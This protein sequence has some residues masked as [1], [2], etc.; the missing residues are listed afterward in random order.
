MS[1]NVKLTLMNIREQVKAEVIKGVEGIEGLEG[2]EGIEITRTADPKFGDF[3]TNLALKVAKSPSFAKASEGKQRAKETKGFKGEQSPMEFAKVLTDSL[4]KSKLVKKLE[5]KEPG[6]VNFWVKD[7]IW[8]KEVGNVLKE[9]VKYGSNNYGEGKKARVEF[10]S[11][12]P[13]GPIHFGNARGG[14]IGDCLASVLSKSGYKVKREYYHNDVGVQV[15]KL[16]ESIKNVHDGKRLE[17]QEYKGQYVAE[18]ADKIGKVA[19]AKEAGK[20]AVE[21]LLKRAIEDSKSMGII[22]DEVYSE[23]E[24]IS[25]GKTK[26]ALAKLEKMGKLV[27]KDGAV[28]FAAEG[29]FLKDRECVVVKGDGSYTYFANDISYH[30]LKFRE[31]PALVIDVFGSNHHGHVPRLQAAVKE[32]GWDVSR[33]HV[34]L[35][36]WVRF[37]SGGKLASMSKRA[38]TLVTVREVLDEVGCDSLRFFILMHDPASHID[39]DLSL[40][41]DKSSKNPVYYVQY[42]HA[43]ICSILSKA[44]PVTTFPPASAPFASLRVNSKPDGEKFTPK[45]S[46][47]RAVGSLSSRATRKLEVNYQLLTTN[48]ELALIKKITELP[49]LIAEISKSF[50]VHRLTTY[51]VGLADLFHKFYENCPVLESEPALREARLNLLRATQIAFK[52]TLS[53]L[54]VSAPEKM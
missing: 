24:M 20:R 10:V 47:V 50:A 52:N 4:K 6:F 34:I 21:I 31:N 37:L 15:T 38:G 3:S 2:T 23:S 51:A 17:D 13:T 7:E 19:D 54:G 44:G 12:N 30:D 1:K 35:Y 5:V 14:P 18:L 28:W 40:A 39:F 25:S 36:Q 8:Q 43:R 33:F 45:R 32:L 48:Y 29:E 49:E 16:G 9:G 42:A 46:E 41:R 53:L 27:K 11:A 26:E 22:F